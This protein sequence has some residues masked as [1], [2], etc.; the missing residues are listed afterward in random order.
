MSTTM[1]LPATSLDFGGFTKT[2]ARGTK[3]RWRIRMFST[4]G[5]FILSKSEWLIAFGA[6][7]F[8]IGHGNLLLDGKPSRIGQ[9]RYLVLT[10][11]PPVPGLDNQCTEYALE[12]SNTI[13]QS[14]ITTSNI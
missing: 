4:V 13:Q 1:A 12:A 8:D 2:V 7:Q 3:R 14:L 5:L 9:V 11:Q 6:L 10:A